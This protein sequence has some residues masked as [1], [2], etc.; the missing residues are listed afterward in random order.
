MTSA[1]LNGL[2][3]NPDA[4][5]GTAFFQFGTS[6]AYGQQVATQPIGPLSPASLF[7]G[8]VSG[9][10]PGTTYHYRF[11]VTSP[12]GISFGA[13][14]TFTT[15]AAAISNE[16]SIAKIQVDRAGHIILSLNDAGPGSFTAIATTKVK[17]GKKAGVA[18]KARR[19]RYGTGSATSTGPGTVTLT[20]NPTKKAK[21]A[22]KRR[23][24][25]GVS[26]SVTFTPT[27]GQAKAKTTALTVRYKR[28]SG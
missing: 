23:K 16:F 12:D 1:I 6:T 5:G 13:D 3:G 15:A 25:L 22:L 19:I 10:T 14:K 7:S 21:R 24:K 8:G 27:G 4:V 17:T 20:I 9:L 2:G 11:G 26:L 18:K 28:K